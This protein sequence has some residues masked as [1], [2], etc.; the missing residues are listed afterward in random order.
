[1]ALDATVAD[2]LGLDGRK[3]AEAPAGLAEEAEEYRPGPSE[4]AVRLPPNHSQLR[5]RLSRLDQL[6][7]NDGDIVTVDYAATSVEAVPE[8]AR[9]SPAPVV[10]VAIHFGDVESARGTT[11]L[12][13]FVP[14]NLLITNSR[15]HNERML[16]IDTD[17]VHIRGVV[18]LTQ[19]SLAPQRIS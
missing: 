5:V 3:S 7:I 16:N 19:R 15:S 14:P 2:V 13:Q 8:R 18:V 9:S 17:D 4:I 12:R 10:V 6:D 11:I 1:M